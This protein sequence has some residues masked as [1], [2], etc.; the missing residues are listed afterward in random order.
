MSGCCYMLTQQ[1]T[2]Q[3][4]HKACESYILSIIEKMHNAPRDK[5]KFKETKQK[6]MAGHATTASSTTA[7][8]HYKQV[9]CMFFCYRSLQTLTRS[10]LSLGCSFLFRCHPIEQR[11]HQLPHCSYSSVAC[12]GIFAVVHSE[13][14]CHNLQERNMP[15]RSTCTLIQKHRRSTG[16][17]S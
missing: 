10:S 2:E 14:N 1:R 9:C 12:D 13:A 6:Q 8:P 7:G 3:Q 11:S 17:F 15:S 4:R 5:Q 16:K